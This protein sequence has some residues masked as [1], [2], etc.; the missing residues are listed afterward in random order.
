[1]KK[2]LIALAVLGGFAGL[3]SA[4]TNVTIYGVVDVAISRDNN[5]AAAGNV[6]RMDSGVQ[7]GSRLG[8]K[9]TEDL[10]GGLS[11]SFQLENGFNVDNGTFDQGGLLF[12]RQAWVGLNGSFGS[13]K[14]GRQY[15]PLFNALD[16]I[17]PFGAGMAGD[18]TRIMFNGGFVSG[19]IPL[20]TNNT[21]NYSTPDMSGFTGAAAYGLGEKAGD[22]AANR[23]LGLGLGY[24]NGPINVQFAYNKQNQQTA[25][26]PVTSNNDIKAAFL[27]GTYD[28]KV[29]K[30]HLAYGES[31]VDNNI[32]PTTSVKTRNWLAGVTI[33]FGA[34]TVMASYIRN[35]VRD[36]SNSNSNQWALGYTYA[37][38]KRTNLYTSFARTTNDSAARINIDATAPAGSNDSLY[39]VGIRH[40]F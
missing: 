4:Q 27:G 14:L 10:G 25:V 9:G 3:T 8:F 26:A 37:L 16:T 23:E 30:A 17:D 29:V 35:N 38:S 24:A 31:T 11:A 18:T 33:P 19:A 39:N 7:S 2:S 28:F 32:A 13:V 20:R 5:N 21:I 40:T 36:I 6:T 1:M 12:G 34:S 15:T 22:S